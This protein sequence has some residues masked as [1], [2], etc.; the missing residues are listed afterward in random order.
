MTQDKAFVITVAVRNPADFA[1]FAAQAAKLKRHGKVAMMVSSLSRK[2][3]E[4][5]P[6]GGS[7]WHE[8]TACLSVLHKF[9]PHPR[10]AP[11]LNARHVRENRALLRSCVKVLRRHKLNAAF[12]THEPFYLPEAFFVKYPHLRGA[13]V[14]HPRRS[15]QEA[16]APCFDTAEGREMLTAMTAELYREVPELTDLAWFT[17]DAGAGICWNE[18][19]YPG[20][21]GPTHCRGLSTGQRVKSILDAFHAGCGNDKLV[22]LMHANFVRSEQES[23]WNHVDRETFLYL[24]HDSR[25]VSTG[26]VVDNPVKGILNPVAILATM[27]KW[28]DPAVRRAYLGFA[29]NYS[30]S[31]ELP[32]VTGMAVDIIDAYLRAPAKGTL[33]RL[34]F[35]HGLCARWAGEK[36]ADALFEALLALDEAYRFKQATLPRFSGNYVGVSMR[37]ITRP[38]VAMPDRLTPDEEA[39]F[40]PHVFNPSVN[41]GRMDYL[42]WHG[43]RLQAGAVDETSPDVRVYAVDTFC[44]KLKDVASALEKIEGK[45]D[46]AVF[47]GMALS[48]RMYASMVRSIGNF[49]SLQILRDRNKEKFA[50]GPRIPPK[51]FS[52]TGDADLL[53]MHEF[54]RDELDNTSQ[55]VDLLENGGMKR[56]V[57]AG[58]GDVED[59]FMLGGD[60]VKQL[61]RKMAIMRRHWKDASEYL[62]TPHK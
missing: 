7:P 30:R 19:L 61:R 58:P 53:Q 41:E 29:T 9:F 10:I 39:Y 15:R 3:V 6:A 33:G 47:R 50:A 62:A 4:D 35:L 59:T 44:G 52:M 14:D 60:V 21:N 8:Y 1:I 25:I 13:R 36:R 16:F 2:T 57:T 46:A 48:L 40:L 28:L 32:E 34:N 42:D 24:Q 18:Y 55:L 43:G 17:N 51:V 45:G 27:E 11:F 38:L 22:V 5:I 12:A 26:P 56:F 37:H 54:M 49:Y 31:H 23:I 20:P